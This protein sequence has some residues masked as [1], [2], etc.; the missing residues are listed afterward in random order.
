MSDVKGRVVFV[1]VDPAQDN[2]LALERALNTNKIAAISRDIAPPKIHI[3][4]AVDCDNT[5]TSADNPA[6]HRDS[7]WFFERVINPLQE[8]GLEYSIEMSWSSDWYGS[9]IKASQ[10]QQAELIMLP[11]TS[12]PSGRGRIFNE[13]IWRLLRTA[14][15]PVLVVQPDSPAERKVILAAVNIQSHK[16]EYQRLN[17]LIIDRSHIT[18]KNN[19]ASLQIIN[20]Y[21]DSLSYPDRGQLATRTGVDNA[22]IHVKAGDPDDVIAETA[23]EI[24]ADLLVIG[25]QKRASRWRGNTSEKII[26]KVTC[27]ILAI[28]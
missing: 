24:G 10:E 6:V 8:S 22:N 26:T 18:A 2:P 23:N 19:N 20:A 12:R 25:T 5:D 27:D 16:P 3:F 4:M 7:E 15:C 9:I 11:L 17:D 1:V 28:N 13:S 21:K 14:D